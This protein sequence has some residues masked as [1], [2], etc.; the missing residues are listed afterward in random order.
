MPVDAFIR[1]DRLRCISEHDGSGHSE[2]Y[3]WAVLLWLDDTTLG[4]PRVV[5][6]SAPG[7][8][9]ASRAVIKEGI[10]DGEDAAMP[11]VQRAFAHRF[12]DGL[13]RRDIGIVVAL[14]EE[15]E[16]PSDAVR[17]A[18]S[19]F[20][21]ELPK[22][23]AEF[24][25]SH[26]RGPETDAERAGIAAAIRPKVREAGK[27]ALS[28]WEKAQVLLGTLDLDDEIGFD[29]FFTQIEDDEQ[30]PS[31]FRLRFEKV[32]ITPFGE[33]RN[34]Y[35]IDGRFELRE[36]PAPDPCQAMIDR[37]NRA[38]AAVDGLEA[39][40]RS[41]QEEA[42]EAPPQQKAGLLREIRRIRAEEVPAAAT[43]LEAARRGLA[44]CRARRATS[45]DRSSVV[46]DPLEGV[47]VASPSG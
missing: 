1:L 24:I 21:R 26:L 19:A 43:A 28:A 39:Q 9:Q 13:Q 18:Y 40:I 11:S 20:V 42:R 12:E 4:S 17:A 34:E 36:P 38:R 7:N 33:L 14:F 46:T 41:L 29:S 44:E 47:L 35:E 30:A 27:D 31:P 8:V 3:A 15:D 2:P 25:T 23:V 45:A 32:S 16:T 22:A 37:V 6:S 10:K 5:G